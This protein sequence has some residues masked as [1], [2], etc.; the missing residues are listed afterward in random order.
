MNN[1]IITIFGATGFIGSETV[2]VLAAQGYILRLPRRHPKKADM[3]KFNG[4]VGQIVPITC[5]YTAKGIDSVIA[6]SHAVINCTGI[7]VEKGHKSFMGTHC[8]LAEDIAKS[9]T[10]NGVEQLVHISALGVDKS[11]SH[12]GKSK[13]SGEQVICK[14]FDKVMIIRPSIVFGVQD[15]FFNMFAKIGTVSPLLPLI[16]GG[17]TLFQPIYVGDVAKAISNAIKNKSLGIYELGGPDIVSFK[18]ILKK[19]KSYTGQKFCLLPLPFFI[20]KIQAVMMSILPNAPITIDQIR[21]LKTDS[22]V[23]KHAMTLSDLNVKPTP[24]D[25]ILP[26]YLERFKK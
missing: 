19:L 4:D 26:S 11:R 21:S 20:A 16:G 6:G 23:D 22:I 13:L 17:K 9:C 12:Y 8:Y 5:D 18:D 2:R 25:Q 24:M 10:K 14:N 7:L 15:N 3:L 1:T